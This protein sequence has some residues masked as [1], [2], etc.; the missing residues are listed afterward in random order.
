[1]NNALQRAK[2]AIRWVAMAPIAAFCA[3]AAGVLL[4]VIN[5]LLVGVQVGSI[6]LGDQFSLWFTDTA[7]NAV[8][9][10]IFVHVGVFI[11]PIWKKHTS[12]VLS[13]GLIFFVGMVDYVA[14]MIQDWRGFIAAT[15]IMVGGV[16]MAI[17]VCQRERRD[18]SFMGAIE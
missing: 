8:T 15:A 10:A 5:H 4:H 9:G 3:I 12:I 17:D 2:T 1:M 6:E 18:R 7:I 13:A 16:L 11:A 14:I